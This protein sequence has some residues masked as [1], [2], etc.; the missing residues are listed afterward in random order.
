M[1]SGFTVFISGLYSG[2]NPQ[3]GVGIARSLR[4]GFP[5]ADIVGVEYSNRCSG[6]HWGDFDRIWLQRPWEEL[7]L[8][9][10]AAEVRR[11]L[12]EGGYWI[13]SIDLEIMWLAE[14]FADGHHPNLLTP[15][16]AAL[17]RVGKP[18]IPAH[19]G[20]PV[21]IPDFTSTDRTDWEL[22]AFCREHDWKVWLKG[23][24]YE[25]VRTPTWRDVQHWRSV[26]SKAWNTEK[27]YLQSHVTGYEESV[28]LCAYAGEIVESVYMRKRDLTDLG[29]T[30]AGDSSPVPKVL[31]RP[32]TK[33]VRDL[34]W[35]G[36]AEFE[37]VRDAGEQLWL[38]ELNPRFPAWVHG[39]TITGKNLPAALLEAASRVSAVPTVAAAEEFTRVVL[40]IPVKPEFPLPPLP[41]PYSG[42]IGHSMKHPSGLAEFAHRLEKPLEALNENG[43]GNGSNGR[44]NG[45]GHASPA[46]DT[47]VPKTYIDDLEKVDLS[48][49]QT[50]ARLFFEG[51][52]AS[53]FRNAAGLA[54]ALSRPG[55]EIR[56][57]YSIKTNPDERLIKLAVENGFLAEAISLLEA[58][59]AID[60][61]FRPD[62]VILNGPAKWWR[63]E[64]MPDPRFYSI[65]CDSIEEMQRVSREMEDG[66]VQ[67]EILG[68]RLRTPGIASRFGI[69]IDSPDSFQRLI[70]AIGR[71]PKNTAFGIHFHTASSN[72][73]VRGW[74]HL[75]ESMLRWCASVQALSGRVV[76]VLD[77]GGGWF[78]EDIATEDAS[79]FRRA[80]DKVP[81]FL[82]GVHQ[83][84]TE[85]GKALAQP[86]MALAMRILEIRESKGRPSEVVVDGSIAELPMCFLHPHRIL[87]RQDGVWRACGRGDAVLLGRS[88]ME[89]DIVASRVN[90]PK[91]ARE[92][93]LLVFCDAGAYDRSMSYAFGCG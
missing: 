41:E 44:H 82:A 42:G 63:R 3:P 4:Q 71:M 57:A 22:H 18:A 86:S 48:E 75:F 35:S 14:V 50:P 49:I 26:L 34:N 88:C 89:H 7:S 62:Q 84:I 37:M 38:L 61:G 73:G 24:Y 28:M 79:R 51:T 67:T 2:T 33:I 70:S 31:L 77:I 27:L 80:I 64:T 53:F 66:I 58:K 60:T 47:E 56:N 46:P 32:L 55:F 36:G 6:I 68:I 15:P 1:R 40:E 11:V 16:L 54:E 69:P 65:F 39:T 76:G 93:D 21:K 23:P 83:M 87:A 19:R 5:D 17:Q 72:V 20:M 10:H 52:A 78:P 12:D 81:E 59:K 8:D 91:S 29:K 30:W 13:S 85:P 90:L 74:W 92:G 43:I 45:N 9:A 25:A